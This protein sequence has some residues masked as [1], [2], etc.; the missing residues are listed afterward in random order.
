VARVIREDTA[1]LHVRLLAVN[2]LA[3]LLPTTVASSL[4]A[5]LLAL[6]GFQLGR[7]TL[8][9]GQPRINGTHGLYGNLKVG[10]DC[11]IDVGCTFDLEERVTIGDR[12]TIGH[13]AMIL[14]SSHEIGPREQRAGDLVRAPVVIEDGAWLG[15]RCI[16]LPGVTIGAG[17]IV[18]AGSLVN[19][20]VPANTR[21]GGT[22]A[23]VV[24]KLSDEQ[25]G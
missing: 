23:K 13:Q 18:Q 3:R 8:V 25:A 20:D 10:A 14:T 19:K 22:P 11:L 5:G 16:V 2:M 7:G 6:A 4:R 21:V 9:R 12:V 15:P 17:A 1:G 24:E